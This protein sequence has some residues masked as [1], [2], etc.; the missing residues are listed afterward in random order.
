VTDTWP[1][2]DEDDVPVPER[3]RPILE[4]IVER[5]VAGDYDALSRDHSPYHHHPL[6][7]L[8]VWA[9]EYPA[10]FVPFHRR[11][12]SMPMRSTARTTMTG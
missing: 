5:I 2:R 7:D 10:T 3:F 1:M 6:H 8:G 11:R 12:G 9:R 4:R